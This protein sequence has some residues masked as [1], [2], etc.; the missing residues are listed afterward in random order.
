M[1]SIT[2][3]QA[4]AWRLRR[5]LLDPPGAVDVEDV[6][7]R[8]GA[9]PAAST[10]VAE[11][12][13]GLRRL[14]P[15]P[16]DVVAALAEGRI[17]RTFAFRGA[18]HLLTADEGADHLALRASNRT[19][20]KPEWVS[21]H[22]VA[23]HEWPAFR[24]TVRDLLAGGPLTFDELVEGISAQPGYAQAGASLGW[25]GWGTVKALAWHGD[26]CF[27]PSKGGQATFQLLAGRNPHWSGVPDVGDAG[28]RAVRSYVR[29]YGPTTASHLQYWLGEG[30]GAASSHVQAWTQG[31]GDE[32]ATVVV[33]GD[34]RL[35]L[36]E[37]LDE[38]A[39]ANP[40]TAVH[41]LPGHDQ[42]VLGPG[43]KDEHV[44]PP[45]LRP[46]VTRGRNVLV[47]GGV[48]RGTWS[49]D[50]GAVVVAW[51]PGGTADVSPAEIGAAVV[52]LSRA[53]DQPLSLAPPG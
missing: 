40:T 1:L 42:W 11:H 34:E 45:A 36:A 38:L 16:G 39:A 15:R 48:V 51:D 2:W 7:R 52:R 43:T 37:D 49:V 22:G 30:L 23:P 20:E 8:L 32:L 44:V 6:V 4:L 53:L 21:H 50:A 18:T 3:P 13:T 14:D 31:L 12:A 35:A 10:A 41:L 33:D 26:L 19:W 25:N 27:A 5:Q 17:I 29:A 28:P 46:L 9:V 24:A 47:V